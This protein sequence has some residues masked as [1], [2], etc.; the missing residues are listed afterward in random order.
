MGLLKRI[1]TWWEGATLTTSL[2]SWLRGRPVG[3][4]ALGNRYFASKR[5]DRRWVIYNGPN[6]A[7]RIPPEWHSW[8]HRQI[9]GPP[10]ES[11]PQAQT[12]T[13][14]WKVARGGADG[15]AVDLPSRGGRYL[16]TALDIADDGSV[17]AGS[18]IVEVR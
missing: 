6:D 4:D 2:D 8:L 15:I 11:L 5:G 3:K 14:S 9:D 18:S 12:E 17:S 1:F 16:L 7:S 13:V 10:D